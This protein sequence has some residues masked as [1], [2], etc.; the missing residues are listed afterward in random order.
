MKRMMKKRMMKKLMKKQMMKKQMM[1]KRTPESNT[2]SYPYTPVSA[3]T[4][5]VQTP[6]HSSQSPLARCAIAAR[7]PPTGANG[8]LCE[9]IVQCRSLGHSGPTT[10]AMVS[11]ND[12]TS[13]G[14]CPNRVQRFSVPYRLPSLPWVMVHL[15][16]ANGPRMRVD[17]IEMVQRMVEMHSVVGP[18]SQQSQPSNPPPFPV[19][20]NSC[21]PLRPDN[22]T[23]IQVHRGRDEAQTSRSSGRPIPNEP[24]QTLLSMQN[25]PVH[26]AVAYVPN[27]RLVLDSHT[28]RPFPQRD[29]TALSY[30]SPRPARHQLR[31]ERA[32][33]GRP[34]TG[35][36]GHAN[37]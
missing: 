17:R 4:M 16:D 1:K 27:F 24:R 30:E 36:V 10:N 6:P 21:V 11:T 18:A 34:R 19:K 20:S 5:P 33:G 12:E 28:P 9:C 23:Q 35:P 3:D 8:V 32:T 2:L 22:A 29:C 26:L 25:N 7:R 14:H 15:G 13:I 31:V 37:R